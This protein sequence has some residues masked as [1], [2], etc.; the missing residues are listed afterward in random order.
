M[1]AHRICPAQAPYGLVGRVLSHSFSPELH[2]ALGS[3]P[4]ALFEIKEADLPR[5]LK[6]AP[7]KGVNV[8]I[9]YKEKAMALCHD[10]SPVARLCGNVNTVVKDENGRLFGD[11]TDFEG[12]KRALLRT[13][14]SPANKRVMILGTGGAAKTA[15]AVVT[16][17]GAADVV[18]VSRTAKP[19]TVTYSEIARCPDTALLINATPVGMSPAV[20]DMP[21]V[22]LK[23]LPGLELVVDL[24][25]NPLS[26]RLLQSARSLGI[27]TE[28][29]LAMLI[30]QAA[31]AA[32]R[33]LHTDCT[34]KEAELLHAF[35]NRMA[36]IVLIGMPGVGKT[37][38]GEKLARALGRPFVDTDRLIQARVG[39]PC[40]DYIQT[41]GIGAFR[42][43]EAAVIGELRARRG[44]VIATGGGAV[45]NPANMMNLSLNGTVVR[46]TRNLEALPVAGRPL[47]TAAGLK[48]LAQEREPLYRRYA[49]QTIDNT[50]LETALSMLIRHFS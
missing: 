35:K 9:P 12:L 36:N 8:T 50:D 43:V 13:G 10:V 1:S 47:S 40:A 42:H 2:R 41:Q 23:A 37:T 31:A 14:F 6:E 21:A 11:N 30:G 29:G 39:C 28:N 46:L 34:A 7:F 33:F 4:Y 17:L 22:D 49:D 24:V 32:E 18:F 3:A 38:L 44:L 19:G 15:G 16:A 26:T 27:R 5:F 25:Y 45:L 20:D 48:Q